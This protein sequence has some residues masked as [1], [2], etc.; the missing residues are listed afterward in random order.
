MAEK[1]D[2]VDAVHEHDVSDKAS[3]E[4]TQGGHTQEQSG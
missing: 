2:T 1:L 4:H 3:R